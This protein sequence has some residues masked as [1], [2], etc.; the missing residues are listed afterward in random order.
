MRLSLQ[1]VV[2]VRF[3]HFFIHMH[4][5]CI[6]NSIFDFARTV[7]RCIKMFIIVFMTIVVVSYW[8]SPVLRLCP[9]FMI[10]EVIG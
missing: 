3:G 2:A 1:E 4:V 5:A 8:L 10:S 9:M 6:V 7:S